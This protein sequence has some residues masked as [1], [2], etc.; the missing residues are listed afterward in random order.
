MAVIA[1]GMIETRGFTGAVEAANTM[2]Q[3]G[4]VKLIGKQITNDNFI[5]VF[6]TG[7][8]ESVK[9]AVETGADSVRKAGELISYLVI[10]NPHPEL[11]LI[12]P[13]NI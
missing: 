10:A 11:N 3:T 8:Y 9:S 2:L 5:T 13:N 1:L 7:E 4:D 12:L 6:I